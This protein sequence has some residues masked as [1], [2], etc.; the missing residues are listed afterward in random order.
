[1][2]QMGPDAAI[3]GPSHSVNFPSSPPATLR[4]PSRVRIQRIA[5][6]EASNEEDEEEEHEDEEGGDADELIKQYGVEGANA[7]ELLG[8]DDD[9]DEGEGDDDDEEAA[10]SDDEPA[11][12]AFKQTTR[13]RAEWQTMAVK[14][15]KI[16]DKIIDEHAILLYIEYSA[17][18]EK[19]TRRGVPIPGSRLGV[20]QLKKLFFGVLR[21]RKPQ[22]AADP[23]KRPRT[24]SS[25]TR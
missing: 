13:V 2:C 4:R 22:D 3:A 17:E 12:T 6:S 18:R 11:R 5:S 14:Q 21:I 16:K 1:M 10:T 15:G 25:N 24:T 8:Y 20:S 7:E 19:K 9:D 23:L